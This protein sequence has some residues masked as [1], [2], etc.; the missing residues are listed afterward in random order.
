MV[1]ITR[2]KM[3]CWSFEKPKLN[4]VIWYCEKRGEAEIT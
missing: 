2:Y 4:K 1:A 3:K